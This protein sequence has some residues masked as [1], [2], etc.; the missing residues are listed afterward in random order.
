[1]TL[2]HSPVQLI[3]WTLRRSQTNSKTTSDLRRILI[4]ARSVFHRRAQAPGETAEA[5]IRDLYKLAESAEFADK[6]DQIRDRLVIGV[7]DKELSHKLQMESDL[8]LTTAVSIIKQAE[9]VKN[10]ICQQRT[11]QLDGVFSRGANKTRHD[12]RAPRK[13]YTTANSH[14]QHSSTTTGYKSQCHRCGTNHPPKICPAYHATCNK[15]H[16]RGHYQRVCRAGQPQRYNTSRRRTHNQSEVTTNDEGNQ[17]YQQ[18]PEN[19][20][21]MDTVVCQGDHTPWYVD[22]TINDKQTVRFKIDTGADVT[23]MSRKTYE[24]LAQ[25]PILDHSPISLSSVNAEI[26]VLGSFMMHVNHNGNTYDVVTYVADCRSDLLSRGA[27]SAMSLLSL[28]AE[29]LGIMSGG[30]VG[31]AMNDVEPFSVSVPRKVPF[32]LKPK[33]DAELDRMVRDGVISPVTG[34][35]AWCSNIVPVEKP[36]GSVRICVDLREVNRA[37]KRENYPIPSFDDLA[38]QF[39]NAAVFS[40]LDARSGYHQIP[41][42][43][44][45]RKITTFITHRGRFCFNR[46]PFGITSASEIFQRRMEAILGDLPGVVIYQ[47]D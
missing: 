30:P 39:K 10:D 24:S 4:H 9:S 3:K 12:E 42:E 1:M 18:P 21:F 14:Q 7:C 44:E 35:T 31:I 16:K 47:D 25:K 22:L 43:E 38:S 20:Y 19:T 5:Y 6:D 33:I 13:P 36:N 29:G 34:P 17:R 46:L 27:A 23:L 28:R 40:I 41:L 2:L 11:N 37:V 15:C 26:N 45:S 8:T 32:A